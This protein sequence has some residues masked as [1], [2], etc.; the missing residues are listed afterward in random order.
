VEY[1]VTTLRL[2]TLF[3]IIQESPRYHPLPCEGSALLQIRH[4]QHP[5]GAACLE[6][7]L[8]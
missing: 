5:M 3:P 4:L 1:P 8:T 6:D 2:A 7:S